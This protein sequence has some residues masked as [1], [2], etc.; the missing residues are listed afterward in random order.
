MVNINIWSNGV[1]VWHWKHLN[2]VVKATWI[3]AQLRESPGQHMASTRHIE[4]LRRSVS[5]WRKKPCAL[6]SR[7]FYSAR[8]ESRTRIFALC[9]RWIYSLVPHVFS[10]FKRSSI[11]LLFDIN[12]QAGNETFLSFIIHLNQ[13]KGRYQ[14]IYSYLCK[15]RKP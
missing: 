8:S 15:L 7:L 2:L 14:T 1:S 4:P 3:H 12:W 9:V 6:F 5:S 13:D 10:C 11:F